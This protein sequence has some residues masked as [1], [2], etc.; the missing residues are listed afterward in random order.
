M[1]DCPLCDAS[2]ITPVPTNDPRKYLTCTKCKLI[3]VSKE[4]HPEPHVAEER[5]RKHQ[6]S[7]HDAGYVS[8]LMQA[9]T[10]AL[11]Y[12]NADMTGLDYGCGPTPTLSLLLEDHNI[13][14]RNYDPIFFP[15]IAHGNYNFIFSTECFEHFISPKKDISRIISLLNPGGILIVM[16]DAWSSM[17][18]LDKWYYIRDFTHVSFYHRQTFDYICKAFNLS[19][20][21]SNERRVFIL[22]KNPI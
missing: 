3:F 7:S 9:V 22:K 15:E 2:D 10:P 6:N 17:D 18:D 14:C 1:V 5:Y 21:F 20:L 16:T 11:Q 4:F 8:F 19:M 12:I 13:N